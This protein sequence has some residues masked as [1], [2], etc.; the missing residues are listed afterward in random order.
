M[1]NLKATIKN[2]HFLLNLTD[3]PP[4]SQTTMMP[5]IQQAK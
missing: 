4:I 1:S 5:Q 3:L 2:L